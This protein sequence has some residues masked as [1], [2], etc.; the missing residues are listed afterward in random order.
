MKHVWGLSPVLALA[1]GFF[2]PAAEGSLAKYI[3]RPEPTY[4]WEKSSETQEGF[5]TVTDLKLRSQVWRGIPWDHTLRIYRPVN[6]R[7]PKTA[8]LLITGGNPG[9]EESEL[10]VL[11]AGSFQAP[12]AILYNIPNQPLFDGKTEDDLIAHTFAEFL[13]SGD[14]T[15]PLL[16]P[17]TKSAVK[18]MDALQAF[19][20]QEWKQ[21]IEGF[22]VT[23]ASKRGWTTYLTG[24]SDPRVKAI[25]PMV[26]DN[27]HFEAQMPRQL[28]LW[29]KYS[30]QIEEYT[31]RGLQQKMESERGRQLTRLVDPWFYRR[32]LT[33]P[34]LLI[35]GA[36]DRYWATDATSF[37]WNDLTGPKSLLTV[38]N[39]GHGLEDRGRVI[40]T[41]GAFF[42][43]IADGR[44][45]PQLSS[46][47]TAS[48]AKRALRLTA[49]APIQEAR[50]WIAR[51]P[52]LDFR[53]SKWESAPMRAEEEG[54][55][56]ELTVPD[57]GGIAW[58][59]EA[60]FNGPNGTYT[61]STPPQVA[62][63]RADQ[64]AGR[65]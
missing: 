7:H 43:Q 35:H 52:T 54:Y 32:Q 2:G 39:S 19:S 24:A 40:A 38:P 47:Q 3:A 60:V 51:A 14:D 53:E 1:L 20:E 6:V 31:R 48:G 46:R 44:P 21:K 12:M 56:G 49:T 62:G 65:S 42:H 13:Q 33:M 28:A 9:K 61:L 41:L 63:K 26:F 64:A 15:W 23:G 5:V 18:A 50:L 27:L 45:F 30:E 58:F 36:N 10:A 22:V 37:F 11:L 25:A 29:G 34:K 8:L 4:H 17:M 55:V 59:A 16:A 57:Q